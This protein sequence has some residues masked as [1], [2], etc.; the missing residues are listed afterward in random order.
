MPCRVWKC[1][2]K[3]ISSGLDISEVP[4]CYLLRHEFSLGVTKITLRIG[5]S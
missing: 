1:V 3:A 4:G 2:P 5:V